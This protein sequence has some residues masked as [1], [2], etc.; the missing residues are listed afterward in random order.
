MP[1]V[2]HPAR[3][4]HSPTYQKKNEVTKNI[5]QIKLKDKNLQD[6]INEEEICNLP[7]KEFRVIIVKM[8][9]NVRRRM[10]AQI[11]KTQEM[12]NK[13]LEYPKNKETM[14]NGTRTEMKNT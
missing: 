12:F 4:E 8:I 9:Q 1:Q 7:V 5:V 10:E 13:D 3:Q 6:Q 2:K 11:K 14:I